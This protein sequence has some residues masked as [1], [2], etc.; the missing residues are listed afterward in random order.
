MVARIDDVNAAVTVDI[1]VVRSREFARRVAVTADAAL[2][3]TVAEYAH[4]AGAGI[5]R[6]DAAVGLV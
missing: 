5:R 4:A 6:V 1:D 3:F 2:E